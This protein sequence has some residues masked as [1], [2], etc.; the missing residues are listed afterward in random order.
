MSYAGDLTPQAA[1]ERL[2]SGAVLVDVR[3]RAE[4]AQIGVPVT[5]GAAAEPVFIEWTR[6]GG[7][8]N[9]T[10]LDELRLR[11]PADAEL[12][13]LCRSGARSVAAAGAATAAGFT[14][15][16]VLDGFEGQPDEAGVRRVNGWKNVGLP[17]D[18]TR[19]A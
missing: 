3:T 5:G 6:A 1:W 14:V 15:Y 13:F 16:N 9:E 19:T 12:L 8:R 18:G 10:F 2:Q 7:V 4:W 11:V 17:T